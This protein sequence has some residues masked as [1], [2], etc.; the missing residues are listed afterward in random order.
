LS[1][2]LVV[3]VCCF[4]HGDS[5]QQGKELYLQV[6]YNLIHRIDLLMW[7]QCIVLSRNTAIEKLVGFVEEI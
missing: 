7:E 6:D 1:A 4:I 5:I 2:V 3:E